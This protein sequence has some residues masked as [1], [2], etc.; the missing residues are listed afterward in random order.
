[1]IE[2]EI[3]GPLSKSQFNFSKKFFDKKGKLEKE[4]NQITIFFKNINNKDLRLSWD[5][6]GN[7]FL[8]IKGGRSNR[9]A[10]RELELKMSPYSWKQ[11][12]DFLIALGFGR[13][14]IG[15][16]QRFDYRYKS[17]K[18]ALRRKTVL[19][20]HFEIELM[21]RSKRETKRVIEILKNFAREMNLNV[22]S[23]EDYRKLLREKWS[24]VPT[25]DLKR[26]I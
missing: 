8:V 20:D 26:F 18:I 17:F 19:G 14:Q 23:E 22:W 4:I 5:N 21:A 16:M 9:F 2:V 11:I 3:R 15:K 1:M 24:N 6:N 12:L 25:Q 7:T 10:R 13:G